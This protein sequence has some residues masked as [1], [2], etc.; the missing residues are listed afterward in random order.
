MKTAAVV[1]TYNRKDLL[2]KNLEAVFG[3]TVLP[4]A[5][6]VIDNHSSDGT[7]EHL[8]SLGYLDNSRIRYVYK[9]EN[10]GGAG[11]FEYGTRIAYEAGYDWIWLMDDDGR[12]ADRYALERLLHFANDQI[13]T[14]PYVM[15]NPLVP[16]D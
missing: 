14:N 9:D 15:V 2:V 3:Q 6:Y 8:R 11:G 4:D 13:Q 10:T 12:P 7:G 16:C 5:V 1:V